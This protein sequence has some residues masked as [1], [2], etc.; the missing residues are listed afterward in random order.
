MKIKTQLID[1]FLKE[2]SISKSQFCKICKISYSSLQ[3]IYSQ[4]F[5]VY[6][7]TIFKVIRVLNIEPKNFFEN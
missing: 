2:K 4:N 3:K 1:E 6:I 5:G 7:T